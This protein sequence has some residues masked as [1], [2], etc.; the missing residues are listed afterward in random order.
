MTSNASQR[1]LADE[2][3][4]HHVSELMRLGWVFKGRGLYPSWGRGESIHQRYSTKH[5][6]TTND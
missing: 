2:Q 6:A 3:V 5:Q 4:Q 1:H